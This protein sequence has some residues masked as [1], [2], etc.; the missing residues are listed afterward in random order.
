VTKILKVDI[1]LFLAPK[2]GAAWLKTTEIANGEWNLPVYEAL[3][4]QPFSE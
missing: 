2:G 3:C 1:F 4:N